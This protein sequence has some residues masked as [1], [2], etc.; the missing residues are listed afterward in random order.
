MKYVLVDQVLYWK[1]PRIILLKCLDKS[2]VE[3]LTTELHGGAC[4]GH[5]Y[6]K[7]TTFKIL[8]FGYYWPTLFI[9]V[10]LQVKTCIECQKF[11]GKHK[12]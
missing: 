11:A 12:L 5:K 10:Y 7:E 6:W 3:A 4:G 1:Y 8:M 2:E 9:D